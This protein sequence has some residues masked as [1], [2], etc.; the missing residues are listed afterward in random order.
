MRDGPAEP[1]DVPHV[2]HSVVAAAGHPV[3]HEAVPRQR[4]NGSKVRLSRFQHGGTHRSH[5]SQGSQVNHFQRLRIT[6]NG[7]RVATVRIP[8]NGPIASAGNLLRSNQIRS[9]QIP[10]VQILVLEGKQKAFLHGIEC[11]AS[12]SGRGGSAARG[13]VPL[14]LGKN[15]RRGQ[16]RFVER[17]NLTRNCSARQ[18]RTSPRDVSDWGKL[19]LL[20]RCQTGF[21]GGFGRGNLRHNNFAVV[22]F[23]CHSKRHLRLQIVESK[24]TDCNK[25]SC[26]IWKRSGV[27]SLHLNSRTFIRSRFP[28]QRRCRSRR[29]VL[30]HPLAQIGR[31]HV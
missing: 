22:F 11:H 16:I 3:R 20:D 18:S 9:F 14:C 31:A 23:V 25:V 5:C 29:N 10:Q 21:P 19:M 2:D 27:Q 7:Q 13:D 28:P 6:S 26:D 17:I 15:S 24:G 30:V 4:P 1:P 8:L 12:D